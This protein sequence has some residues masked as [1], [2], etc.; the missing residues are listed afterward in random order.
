ML[1]TIYSIS[2]RYFVQPMYL[3]RNENLN[4][5]YNLVTLVYV[6]YKKMIL[7]KA[8]YVTL[9]SWWILLTIF[10]FFLQE[11]E[12]KVCWCASPAWIKS[13]L[14]ISSNAFLPHASNAKNYSTS[15]ACGCYLQPIKLDI[16]RIS[17]MQ[18]RFTNLK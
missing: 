17:I 11:W 10:L 6:Y 18:R 16:S 13:C 2:I 8:S 14:S 12:S 15:I 3:E 4:F 1:T 9:V 5:F 7:I